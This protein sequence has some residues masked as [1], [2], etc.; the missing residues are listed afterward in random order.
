MLRQGSMSILEQISHR[1]P[2]STSA[3]VATPRRIKHAAGQVIHRHRHDTAFAAIVLRGSYVEAGDT[4]R[5]RV[6][7]G[8]VILHRGFESHLDRIDAQ[9]TE[10]LVL[11]LAED[12]E[13][14]ILGNVS[15]P[16]SIV[17]QSERC[18]AQAV[19]EL[20]NQLRNRQ[21]TI[22]DW[23]DILASDL[24]ADPQLSIAH[25]AREHHLHPGS[26]SRAFRQQFGLAPAGFR[27]AARAHRAVRSITGS[28]VPLTEIAFASGFADHA[29]MVNAVRRLT[30]LAPRAL[31]QRSLIN[32]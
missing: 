32:D 18:P 4:G 21:L 3:C 20:K 25:W 2:G 28:L 26:V 10:V 7:P 29:H 22:E 13:G 27:Y 16:D 5:H 24:I 19:R 31:R 9:G 17:L 1:V 14:Q 6:G 23:P 30:G 11:P 12:Y 8:D 15:D